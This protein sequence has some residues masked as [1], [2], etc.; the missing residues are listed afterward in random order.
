MICSATCHWCRV[1]LL[2]YF[3]IHFYIGVG[4]GQFKDGCNVG[5][6]STKHYLMHNFS[7]CFGHLPWWSRHFDSLNQSYMLMACLWR[8]RIRQISSY[9]Q[10]WCLQRLVFYSFCTCRWGNEYEL[11]MIHVTVVASRVRRCQEHMCYFRPTK[12]NNECDKNPAIVE[13][14]NC[15]PSLLFSP[16]V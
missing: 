5:A 8:V 15:C 1:R 13:G 16:C 11:G 10:N 7:F 6:T 14:T 4:D 3:H 9:Y 12:R 2:A